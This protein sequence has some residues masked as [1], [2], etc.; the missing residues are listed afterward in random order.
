MLNFLISPSLKFA[1]SFSLILGEN[2]KFRFKKFC[3]LSTIIVGFLLVLI[4]CIIFI[5][6]QVSLYAKLYS[7][8]E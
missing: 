1:I 7:I 6:S 8:T 3:L 4:V 2:K 5:F